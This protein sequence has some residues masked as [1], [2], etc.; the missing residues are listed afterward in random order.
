MT[1]TSGSV[2]GV[3]YQGLILDFGGVLTTSLHT[4][5]HAFEQSEGLPPGALHRAV[6]EN[7]RG[8][9]AYADLELGRSTQTEWNE[10]IGAILGIP[11]QG[12]MGRLLGGL[13]R[14]PEV[15]AAAEAARA[16][17]ART[18]MLSNSF[19]TEPFNVYE[20][21]G[22]LPL[23]D[24][25]VLSGPEG[26]RKPDPEIYRRTTG[27]LGLPHHRCL[28]VDDQP[29]NLQP[30]EALGLGTLLHTAPNTTAAHLTALFQPQD[31][32]TPTRR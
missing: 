22:L 19:G 8:R 2:P 4:N 10:T 6:R 16:A 13:A 27:R 28:L 20:E 1:E 14:E 7:P 24:V 23:F 30:A 17:G 5:A 9:R 11:P 21:L 15:V 31:T 26:V 12:L 3:A 29:E 32:R 25:V 18:A